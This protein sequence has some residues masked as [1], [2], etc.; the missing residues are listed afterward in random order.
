MPT[1]RSDDDDH[2][3]RHHHHVGDDQ[4][5]TIH[6]SYVLILILISQSQEVANKRAELAGYSQCQCTFICS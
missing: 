3:N 6:M 2:D 1:N 5:H 4:I